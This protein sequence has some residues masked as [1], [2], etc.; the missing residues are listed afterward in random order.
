MDYELVTVSRGPVTHL[1][2]NDPEARNALSPRML[3]DIKAAIDDLENDPKVRVIVMRGAGKGFCAG[4]KLDSLFSAAK[5]ESFQQKRLREHGVKSVL[6]AIAACHK[7]IIAQVHGFALAGGLGLAAAC[8]LIV[9]AKGAKLGVPEILRGLFP[10]N[11]MSPMSRNIPRTKLF[12]W[13][14]TGDLIPPEEALAYGLI[15]KLVEPEELEVETDK[16]A[17]KI[18]LQSGSALGLGKEAYYTMEGME[19][20]RSFD[21]LTEMLTYTAATENAKEG[22]QAF[23]EKRD[24]VWKD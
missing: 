21:Y 19:L 11:I 4:A 8:D 15:N 10:Y 20:F 24:P 5:D 7:I 14:F 17:Q 13:A 2:L 18:A 23:F 3:Q 1:T 6:K 12:E 16:L 9:V 22:I